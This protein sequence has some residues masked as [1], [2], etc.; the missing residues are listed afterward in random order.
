MVI[1]KATQS[2]IGNAAS[3][4]GGKI[5]TDLL[6]TLGLDYKGDS[7]VAK[8]LE[9][10]GISLEL[11]VEVPDSEGLS[12]EKELSLV[13][14]YQDF[15]DMNAL[16]D[17][18]LAYDPL[19][20]SE[21]SKVGDKNNIEDLKSIA[22]EC[23]IKAVKKFDPSRGTYRLGPYAK[24]AIRLGLIDYFHNSSM[25]KTSTHA[26]RIFDDLKE[27]EFRNNITNGW[28][29]SDIENAASELNMSVKKVREHLLRM[30]CL[31]VSSIEANTKSTKDSSLTDYDDSSVV[32]KKIGGDSEE[33]V[34][35]TYIKKETTDTINGLLDKLPDE[36]REVIKVM[37]YNES[38]KN[39]SAVKV[40]RILGID[41]TEVKKLVYRAFKFL[42]GELSSLGYGD[43]ALC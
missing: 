29:Q 43:S 8:F 24:Q 12:V 21:A 38:G 10:N 34:E 32:F 13:K 18:I 26:Q 42:R 36:Q 35:D 3:M 11:S 28:S 37:Y 40:G 19:I 41:E 27:F 23:F 6:A 9:E 20:N 17:L 22:T 33:L 16:T 4:N 5:S 7:D 31:N 1:K 25:I 15:N 2:L 14:A 30:N 39:L